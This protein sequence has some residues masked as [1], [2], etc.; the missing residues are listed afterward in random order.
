[1]LRR[2][3][4][5]KPGLPPGSYVQEADESSGTIAPTI[6]ISDYAPDRYDRT[7]GAPVAA[8]RPTADGTFRWIRVEGTPDRELLDAFSTVFGIHALVLEDIVSPI[9]RIKVEDYDDLMFTILKDGERSV[10]IILTPTTIIT[11]SDGAD[12]EWC[13]P[14][15]TRLANP[16]SLIRARGADFLY[17]AVVD[18]VVDRI[19]P[20]VETLEDGAAALESS[21]L[22]TPH[23][24]QIAEIHRLRTATH[25]VRS[26]VWAMRDLV[27]QIERSTHRF[28]KA[29][30]LIYF[31][32]I[33]D[34]VVHLID[35]IGMLRDTATGLMDLY[36]SGVSNRMNEVMKVLTIIST[37]FIPITF[38]AG[39]YGMNFR[40]MPELASRW[41]YPIVLGVMA[42]IAVAMV[43]F[44]RRRKWL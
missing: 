28:I 22:D 38:V 37:T 33:H 15:E 13:A 35:E 1:M 32:D 7:V 30:M 27:S 24:R 9:Q 31:R 5:G 3:R 40:H 19:Y 26:T 29:D 4:F 25:A 21:I 17:Y 18:L 12:S 36:M 20:I 6:T 43:V 2:R 42:S 41:G 11:V 14:I 10:S 39:V 8:V 23:D 16:S 34:H 44:F